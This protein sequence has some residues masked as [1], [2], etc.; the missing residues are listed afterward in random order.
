[1]YIREGC[2]K[3]GLSWM[4]PFALASASGGVA[5]L[6]L[7][8]IKDLLS[9]ELSSALPVYTADLPRLHLDPS[10]E[11]D[12]RSFCFGILVGFLV[13]PILELLVLVRQALVIY[14]KSRIFRPTARHG[15]KFV[16]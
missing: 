13:W 3:L 11:L 6:T 10:W 5:G 8:L 4:R 14:L 9:G 12:S 15:W 2:P 7:S 16:E 1:M